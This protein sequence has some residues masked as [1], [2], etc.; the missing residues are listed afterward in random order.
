MLKEPHS[1]KIV[2]F[3][4]WTQGSFHFAQLAATFEARGMP[5]TLVHLGSWGND[6]GRPGREKI[7][8][9]AVRDIATYPNGSIDGMLDAERPDAVIFLSTLTFAH[10][11][12][13]RYCRRRGIPT[14][15]L[16]HGLEAAHGDVEYR[17]NRLAHVRFILSKMGKMLRRT[18][19][20]YVGSLMKTRASVLDYFRFVTDLLR[21][22]TG[23]DVWIAPDDSRTTRCCVY[24]KVDI[25]HATRKF[26]FKEEDVVAVGNPDLWRFGLTQ[27]MVGMR[28]R[29]PAPDQ[30]TIMYI[31]T[32]FASVGGYLFSSVK[33]YVD[34]LLMTA[35]GLAA[36]GMKMLFKYKPHPPAHVEKLMGLLRGSN[37]ELVGGADF[38]EKLRNC[39]AC[40]AETTTVALIPALLGIPL[41]LA[42]FG[43]LKGLHF[44]PA[45]T[46]YPRAHV[47]Q[48]LSDVTAI[49]RKDA[50]TFDPR[51]LVDWA[52][53]NSGPL[54]AEDRP[55]R[56]AEVVQ[57]LAHSGGS[58]LR[59]G[60][61]SSHH[62][63]FGRSEQ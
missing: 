30:R 38:L 60:G 18:L 33:E 31:E 27:E 15:L 13:I 26:Q 6:P 7:G 49:L 62:R 56:I 22:T 63:A 12:C 41:L 19:P 48:S 44:G 54:P 58:S 43:A 23:K 2:G 24:A 14:L 4:S 8:D 55:V 29:S 37:I 1:M 39:S 20:C 50:E 45:L 46:T 61:T 16:Y 35:E 59:H 25:S 52:E 10:R 17:V 32:G 11:A 9:L 36:Q 42:N 53:H 51:A 3:D 57:D 28:A 5:L 40:I 47:L 21:M 34:H